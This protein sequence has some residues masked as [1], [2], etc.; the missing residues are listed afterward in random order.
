M[1]GRGSQQGSRAFRPAALTIKWQYSRRCYTLDIPPRREFFRW[2]TLES[3]VEHH[4]AARDNW[5]LPA[6]EHLEDGA[7]VTSLKL[8]LAASLAGQFLFDVTVGYASRRVHRV[9]LCVARNDREYATPFRDGWNGLVRLHERLPECCAKPLRAGKIFLPDRYQRKACHRDL[10]AA[11]IQLPAAGWG[12]IT[13]VTP[14]QL[15]IREK[16]GAAPTLLSTAETIRLQQKLAACF[17]RMYDPSRRTGPAIGTALPGEWVAWRARGE[18]EPGLCLVSAALNWTRCAPAQYL[19]RLMAAELRGPKVSLPVLP[20]DP[21]AA[22]ASLHVSGFL[23]LVPSF[24][25]AS[26]L[27]QRPPAFLSGQAWAR[28][29]LKYR[30]LTENPPETVP[31]NRE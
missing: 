17:L 18:K 16:F 10:Q 2:E 5:I 22:W 1:P 24:G 13:P 28:V 11:L 26:F 29:L 25:S 21:T 20:D 27:P 12:P 15:G 7:A 6:L 4:L 30:W 23:S 14:V 31:E 19:I 9:T 3:A 8:D